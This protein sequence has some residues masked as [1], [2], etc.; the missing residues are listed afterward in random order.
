MHEDVIKKNEVS[1]VS[2]SHELESSCP[3]DF[4]SMPQN[5]DSQLSSVP[6]QCSWAQMASKQINQPI[7]NIQNT[8]NMKTNLQANDL[9]ASDDKSV[10][11]QSAGNTHTS[12]R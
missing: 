4:S 6:Q 9:S 1:Q 3:K 2:M 7:L 11:R 12:Q 10:F 8:K 5:D